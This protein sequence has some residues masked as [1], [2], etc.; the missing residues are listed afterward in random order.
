MAFGRGLGN[1]SGY[2]MYVR[3]QLADIT[4][5]SFFFGELFRE[6]HLDFSPEM[7]VFNM[8][9]ERNRKRSIKQCVRSNCTDLAK[10]VCP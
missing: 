10:Q 3:M 4:S 5:G 6:V 7:E 1:Y 8:L 2:D 9:F